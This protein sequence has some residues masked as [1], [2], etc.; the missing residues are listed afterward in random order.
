MKF[1]DSGQLATLAQQCERWWGAMQPENLALDAPLRHQR[2]A[3]YTDLNRGD[4]AY[5]R[6]CAHAEDV[7]LQ[8][9]LHL[10]AHKL[11]Q[12]EIVVPLDALALIAG[13]LSHINSHDF[14]ESKLARRLGNT[15]EGNR[16]AMSELRFRQLLDSRTED[17]LYQ[18]MRRALDLLRGTAHVG[19]LAKDLWQCLYEMRQPDYTR[20]ADQRLKV[21]W[22]QEYYRIARAETPA[23]ATEPATVSPS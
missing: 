22:A 18:R 9:A 6:R 14:G 10:L 5:L 4:R 16:P 23:S 13:V 8:P 19:G 21:R 3:P 11:E 12:L 17:E 20:P 15:V 2:F 1:L 7:L